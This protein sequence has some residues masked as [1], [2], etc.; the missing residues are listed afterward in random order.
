MVLAFDKLEGLGNDF[1]VVDARE[2]PALDPA[3]ARA[4]C[5]RHRGIGAD[6]VLAVDT[7]ACAMRVINA[8]GS[9]PEMCGNGIRCVMLWLA[10]RGIV[11]VGDTIEIA[12]DA[13]PHACTLLASDDR[14]A[15]VRVAMRPYALG[16]ATELVVD[17]DAGHHIRGTAVSMGNPHLVVFDA[18]LQRA[19][20]VAAELE[21]HALFPDRVNVGLAEQTGP[22]DLT[23]RV[24]ERGVGYTE[25]CGT[26]ACA[27]AAAAVETGRM[28]RGVPIAVRLPGGSLEV[29]VGERGAP[30]LMTGPARYV[31]T[32][33]AAGF[34]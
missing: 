23:L 10:R 19:P 31:F 5:D 4:L 20:E 33:S 7:L 24:F 22:S 34:R 6:G 3:L 1:V 11:A 14:D 26:G 32:G 17:V 21:R 27:A 29:V 8:D 30:V 2:V 25:A 9:R 13:G 15:S 18:A 12:T 28:P 16:D